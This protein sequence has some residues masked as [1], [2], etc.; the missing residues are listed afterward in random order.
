MTG[1]ES[2]E[3]PL[4]VKRRSVTRRLTAPPGGGAKSRRGGPCG[5]QEGR[6][7]LRDERREGIKRRHS[8]FRLAIGATLAVA[9]AAS[10]KYRKPF[11]DS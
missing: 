2:S 1:E 9:R 11:A 8:R 6:I 5:R 3:C 4:S 7:A 10:V